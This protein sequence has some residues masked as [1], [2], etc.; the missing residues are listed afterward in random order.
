MIRPRR[1]ERPHFHTNWLLE[2]VAMTYRPWL[3]L[4]FLIGEAALTLVS[5]GVIFIIISRAAGPEVLGTYALALAW[6]AVFQG[7]SSFGIPE[8]ILRE[9]GAHGRDAAGQV[10]H[11]MLLGLGSGFLAIC[12]MLTTVRFLGYSA[13]VVQVITVTSL[14]LIPVF[15]NTA[16]RSVF[17]AQRQMHLPFL[18]ALVEATIMLSASL[19]LLFS[20]YG[21]VALMVAVVVAKIASA[22]FAGFQLFRRVLPV[23]PAFDP[24]TLFQTARPV[25]TFGIGNMIGMLSLRINVIMVSFWADITTVGHYAAATKIMEIGLIISNMFGPLLLSRMAHSFSAKGNRDPNC[26]GA[27]YEIL[28]AVVVAPCVGVWVFAG[29]I[30]ETLFGTGFGDALWI[31]RILMIYVVTETAD[32]VMSVILIAT[33]RQRQDAFCLAFNLLTN[34]VLN[35]A[36]LPVLGPIGAAIGRVAGGGVSTSLRHLLISQAL[37]PVNWLHFARKPALISLVAGSVCFSLLDVERPAWLLVFYTAV[38]LVSLWISSSFSFSTIKD[39]MSF[40]S[41][42]D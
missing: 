39:M 19:Y 36:L 12:L 13:Y 1:S 37:T 6:L 35:L 5:G 10:V 29:L 9:A 41:T 21:V 42:A 7:V 40:P 17:V 28:F 26:F 32:I 27:W 14:A 31:L 34:I 8:Y 16:C 15:L 20:G 25:L 33:H 11:A 4:A 30:L 2:S 38:C 22:S 24:R 3:Q 18:A 23:W